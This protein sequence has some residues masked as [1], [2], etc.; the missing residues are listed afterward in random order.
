MLEAVVVAVP[1]SVAVVVYDPDSSLPV[2]VLVV[3]AWSV[4][5]DVVDDPVFDP[6]EMSV[7]VP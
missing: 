5:V 4:C 7:V 6:F 3:S 2:V 1:S